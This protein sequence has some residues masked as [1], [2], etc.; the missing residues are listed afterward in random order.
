LLHF[1]DII[2]VVSITDTVA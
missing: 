1:G 2:I